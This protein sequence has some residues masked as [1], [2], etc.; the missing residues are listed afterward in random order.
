VP[1]RIE[2]RRE[3]AVV[4]P[5]YNVERYLQRA[6]D[7]ALAQTFTDFHIYAV[8]DNSTDRTL[9]VLEANAHRCS[10]VSQP[11]SGP[12]AARNRAIVMSQSPFI[13]FLD[14]DD[15]WLPT[16]LARQIKLL[17]ED[18]T[19]GLVCCLSQVSEPGHETASAFAA[20]GIPL[21][22]K[23][24]R[25][26]VR[27]CFV[28]T[29][30]VVVRRSCLLDVGLFNEALRVSEDF[31]LWLR[32]AARWRIACLPEVLAVTH[33]RSGSLS[34]AI[35]TEERLRNGV[36]ALEHVRAS[37]RGLSRSE[38][39]ALRAA[40]SERVYFHGSYLLSSGAKGLSRRQLTSTLKL[41]PTYWKALAK[42]V[43]SFLPADVV[44]SLCGLKTIT[45]RERASSHGSSR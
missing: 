20:D 28:F 6:L 12:A 43:L 33:K 13:A 7:S 27:S 39:R 14:A 10:F 2:N 44:N 29:P 15:E 1:Q 22:G 31:N 45:L 41:Q 30:T 17:K 11:H 35:S 3:V 40:L 34:V 32:I 4:V 18:P 16:K 24:F 9:A 26:L 5:C 25:H 36:I 42:L 23:L 21:S 19:L 38:A 8:N 37:C